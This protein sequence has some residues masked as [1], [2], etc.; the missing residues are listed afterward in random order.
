MQTANSLSG[1][2]QELERILAMAEPVLPQISEEAFTHRISPEKW[3]YKEILGHLCDSAQT[4]IRRFV[5]GQYEEQP[6]I[7]YQQDFWVGAANYQS[8][9]THALIQFWLLLN[10]HIIQ[11]LSH[12]PA[13]NEERIC[14]T[15]EPHT[16]EWLA[17][18]YNK[19]L[20]HHLN[21]ILDQPP[22]PYP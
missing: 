22:V 7:V 17:A 2:I 20:L 10:R 4:N 13:G 16:I 19:H 6:F 1:S 8:Y 3:S 14:I 21:A 9:D 18:D 11:V 15:Q 12:I 5:V